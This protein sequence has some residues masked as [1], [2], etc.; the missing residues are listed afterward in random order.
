MAEYALR[1]IASPMGVAEYQL[2]R[3]IPQ[4][5]ATNVPSIEQIETEFQLKQQPD[6]RRRQKLIH[7]QHA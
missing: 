2:L 3:D 4:P 1:G 6:F 5:L 7:K